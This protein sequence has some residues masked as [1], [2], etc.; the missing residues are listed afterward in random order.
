MLLIYRNGVF[1]VD[2]QT[3]KSEQIE[4]GTGTSAYFTDGY[5]NVRIR[6]L[7]KTVGDGYATGETV[8]F[9]P[10]R[11]IGNGGACPSTTR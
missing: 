4:R 3:G 1:R 8:Y 6:A 9:Y 2:T 11:T 10:P 5:G 7:T